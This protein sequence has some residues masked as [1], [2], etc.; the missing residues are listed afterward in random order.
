MDT[1]DVILLV[2]GLVLGYYVVA[3]YGG[4]ARMA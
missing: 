3:H 1:Q 4:T 2:V